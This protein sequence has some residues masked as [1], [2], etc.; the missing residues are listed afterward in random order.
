MNCSIAGCILTSAAVFC[1]SFSFLFPSH[2]NW[3]RKMREFELSSKGRI[4][5]DAPP[6]Y[7]SG[8]IWVEKRIGAQQIRCECI[9]HWIRI[10]IHS[11]WLAPTFLI[12]CSVSTASS[13]HHDAGCYWQR[14]VS[15]A[16]II[17]LFHRLRCTMNY[18]L[19]I[20]FR[21]WGDGP[22]TRERESGGERGAYGT[23]L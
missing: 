4:Q 16:Y 3:I 2:N 15:A 23:L 1:F 8:N 19:F 12:S 20:F 5:D 18:Y 22:R 6:E 21:W 10:W 13:S 17:Q 11:S 9:I 7:L 14:I